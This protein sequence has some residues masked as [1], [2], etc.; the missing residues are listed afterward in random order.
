MARLF[1]WREVANRGIANPRFDYRCRPDIQR[2]LLRRARELSECE[3]D[4]WVTDRA[5]WAQRTTAVSSSLEAAIADE[6]VVVAERGGHAE[7]VVDWEKPIGMPPDNRSEALRRLRDAINALGEVENCLVESAREKRATAAGDD[8][9]RSHALYERMAGICSH[10]HKTIESALK[11]VVC[12][13][14]GRSERACSL[15]ELA[16]NIPDRYK[17]VARPAMNP[18][19]SA[20]PEQISLW[21]RAGP[22]MEQRPQLALDQIEATAAEVARIACDTAQALARHFHTAHDSR[23]LA[24]DIAD[25]AD[26]ADTARHI[27]HRLDESHTAPTAAPDRP[28]DIC[29]DQ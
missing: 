27:R 3:A 14:G 1:K 17:D 8:R 13:A 5:E 21:S 23:T 22:G 4:V 7:A 15:T 20:T 19:N 11:T 28:G 29:P 10:S 24:A 9:R 16:S 2:R 12:L 6:A 25:I 26:I 18:R